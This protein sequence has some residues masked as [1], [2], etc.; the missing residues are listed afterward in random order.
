MSKTETTTTETTP[1]WEGNFKDMETFSENEGTVIPAPVFIIFAEYMG[2]V[3]YFNKHAEKWCSGSVPEL[4][5]QKVMVLEAK[6]IFRQMKK[7]YQMEEIRYYYNCYYPLILKEL[8][9]ELDK[10][11]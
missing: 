7:D 4:H 6:C 2:Y 5:I 8:F 9:D 10:I 1:K 11:G 3:S